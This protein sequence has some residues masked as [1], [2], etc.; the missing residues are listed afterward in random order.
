MSGNRLRDV[1]DVTRALLNFDKP[2]CAPL[3]NAALES[4]P[5]TV[6]YRAEFATQLL[7]ATSALQ[8]REAILNFETEYQDLIHA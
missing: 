1:I 8:Q 4:L 6:P 2:A 7:S 3:L 5:S